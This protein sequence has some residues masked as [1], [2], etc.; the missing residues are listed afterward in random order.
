M[1]EPSYIEQNNVINVYDTIFKSFADTRYNIW[2]AVQ[3]FLDKQSKNTYGLEIG[4]GNGKNMRYA[5]NS[6]LRMSGIDTCYSFVDM[7]RNTY[8]L[9]VS[10][11]NAIHQIYV[12]E[13]FD[14]A[15]S[16]AVF[17]HLSTDMNRTKVMQN[18]INI[19]KP[20]G[21]GLV[22]VWAVEQEPGSKRNFVPGD[23]MVTWYK[24]YYVDNVKEYEQHERYYY[25]F[26]KQMF[27]NYMYQ[28]TDQIIINNIYNEKGNWICDFTKKMCNIF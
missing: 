10:E 15:I 27:T 16:V 12:D 3:I 11:S 6:G 17:H 1:L 25:V 20:N 21:S 4:C 7:C 8:H 5:I 19:L 2:N 22:T 23:N 26:N 24:P 13:L 18:M 28:F 9:D 14:F